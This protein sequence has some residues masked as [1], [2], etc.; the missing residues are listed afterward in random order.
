LGIRSVVGTTGVFRR[1]Y[2]AWF[3]IPDVRTHLTGA[4]LLP[5][6]MRLRSA[7][8]LDVG[9]GS[10]LLTCL[11]ASTLP[12]ARVCGWDRDPDAI[13]YARRLAA[14]HGVGNV[15]FAAV[16]AEHSAYDATPRFAAITSLAV[17]QF[18]ADVPGTLAH[19][20]SLLVPGGHLVL[21]VPAARPPVTFF[22]RAPAFGKRLPD[23]HEARGGFSEAECRQMI[24]TAGLD[25]VELTPVIK[26]PTRIAKDVFYLA[27]SIH[28][29]VAALLCPLLNRVTVR[30]PGYRGAGAGFFIVARKPAA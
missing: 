5:T 14:A 6:M 11:V 24:A 1:L 17:L 4:Y 3:G 23:F 19:F 28:R 12:E 9:C 13:D 30:D 29:V 16:D 20:S 25:L 10:G 2:L 26:R 7:S 15:E 22:M 18:V 21:Q 27:H 8:I